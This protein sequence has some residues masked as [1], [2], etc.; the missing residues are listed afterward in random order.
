MKNQPLDL[1]NLQT[2]CTYSHESI[3]TNP[4]PA[5]S[6]DRIHPE[7]IFHQHSFVRFVPGRGELLPFGGKLWQGRASCHE[8]PVWGW[9]EVCIH[10]NGDVGDSLVY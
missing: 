1:Q 2:N 5:Y 4:F 8:A 3:I 7:D 6:T 9:F 10:K